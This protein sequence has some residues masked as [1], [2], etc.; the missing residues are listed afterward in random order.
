MGVERG[1]RLSLQLDA[2]R[3][4]GELERVLQDQIRSTLSDFVYVYA[5]SSVTL[6][7][8]VSEERLADI[9]AVAAGLICWVCL[10]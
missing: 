9:R 3:L 1:E 4:D 7:V 8:T 6:K 10:G 2:G 5:C